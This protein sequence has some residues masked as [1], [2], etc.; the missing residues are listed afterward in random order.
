M[1]TSR[2]RAAPTWQELHGQ[3]PP[4]PSQVT[5]QRWPSCPEED[6]VQERKRKRASGRPPMSDHTQ[7]PPWNAGGVGGG[8][9]YRVLLCLLQRHPGLCVHDRGHWRAQWPEELFTAQQTDS[10]CRLPS[11]PRRSAHQILLNIRNSG[12]SR[13]PK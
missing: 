2:R 6:G 1:I 4:S 13:S 10:V 3:R 9:K 5:R 12:R 7:E 8:G 11:S